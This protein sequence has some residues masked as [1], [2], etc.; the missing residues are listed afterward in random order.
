MTDEPARRRLTIRV[1]A[2][3]LATLFAASFTALYLYV[4]YTGSG[5]A[6]DAATLGIFSGLRGQR[7]LAV[8]EARDWILFLLLAAVAV[9]SIEAVL[10][11]KLAAT[12]ATVLLV[13]STALVSSAFKSGILPRPDL[14]DFAYGYTTF[15]SGHSALSLAAVIALIW[16][17][18]RWLRPV[19]VPFLASLVMIVAVIS[20]L[21]FAHRGSDVVGGLFLASA[22][23]CGLVGVSAPL[24]SPPPRVRWAV[25]GG[26]VLAVGLLL[27]ASAVVA[28]PE[29]GT[30]GAL[31]DPLG[32]ALFAVIG[33]TTTLTLSVQHRMSRV[34]AFPSL[35]SEAG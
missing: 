5:Q 33:G 7:Y 19:V 32:W 25:C 8:Y 13:G 20:L 34:S 18:P 28:Y 12:L 26:V 21:S 15:P 35:P 3:S 1:T 16:L 6:W 11:R 31:L 9:A 4:T 29:P 2:F 23:G 10:R 24:S 22:L 14:G 17:G 27:F 30:A